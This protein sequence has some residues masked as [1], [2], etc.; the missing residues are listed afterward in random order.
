MA[1]TDEPREV[2]EYVGDRADEH[3]RAGDATRRGEG[4]AGEGGAVAGDPRSG[5]EGARDE[6]DLV[7][8]APQGVGL[9]FPKQTPLYHAAHA[10]R[11]DRQELIHQYEQL[12]DCRLV[13]MLDQIFDD[14][15]TMFE[16]LL[17]DADP[18]RDLH[19]MLDSPGGDGEIAVR[20]V[21]AAQSRCRELTVV[22]PNQ[23]KS[24]ATILVLGA[25][26]ILMGP[27][28]DLGPVDPQF[29]MPGRGLYS[30][31][32]LLAAVKSA[33]EAIVKNPDSYPLHVSMLADITGV[34]VE[35]AR[36]ALD[37]STDLVREA[38]GSNPDRDPDDVAVLT[39]ALRQ[40]L[41]ETPKD[42]GAV[43][44]AADAER[45]GLPVIHADPRGEQ[46]QLVWRLWTK[47]WQLDC[48]VYEGV[49]A[50]H[51]FPRQPYV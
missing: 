51:T 36:S 17:F 18:E 50:S 32:D 1:G 31:K 3:D 28:S 33:E 24:A 43:F 39:E 25:H 42:H 40:P 41:I 15:V 26:Y 2:G 16:E 48:W 11:Y 45:V 35:Q 13:V 10:A 20:L 6:A 19:L 21:R 23:A 14:S 4:R 37:R 27:T 29:P 22:V 44:G 46:W 34:M 5:S 7:P 30:A 49:K 8:D 47:Y 38:L 9:A 12:F